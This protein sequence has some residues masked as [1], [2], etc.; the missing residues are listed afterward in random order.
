MLKGILGVDERG[1]SSSSSA[2]V[3]R[4]SRRSFSDP[5]KVT[6]NV[7]RCACMHPSSSLGLVSGCILYLTQKPA[8]FLV[9]DCSVAHTIRRRK[10]GNPSMIEP[11]NAFPAHLHLPTTPVLYWYSEWL[12]IRLGTRL[13]PYQH[14]RELALNTLRVYLRTVWRPCESRCHDRRM[15]GLSCV[16]AHGR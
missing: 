14:D 5:R 8:S 11:G 15:S 3:M 1:A 10:K 2:L 9:C 7:T 6:W 16:C 4:Q 13:R 12:D